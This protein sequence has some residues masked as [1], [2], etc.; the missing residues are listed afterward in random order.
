M[1]EPIKVIFL[2]ID[3]V[4]NS[5]R[6]CERN[7][8]KEIR[9]MMPDKI[10]LD[11][12]KKIIKSTKA[13]I[14]ISSAWRI[15]CPS[16][17][18]WEYFF[19]ALGYSFKVIGV[20]PSLFDAEQH[21]L[22]RGYEIDKWI[23]SRDEEAKKKHAENWLITPVGRFVIID[24]DGDM[25]HLSDHLFQTDAVDGLTEEIADRVIEYLNKS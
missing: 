22:A 20:T 24:D 7:K 13:K 6:S 12:L 11:P 3:G 1:L 23:N 2:D 17:G 10:H 8:G 25:V 9:Q 5:L 14:V 21:R 16:S 15:G 19:E 4:L 18:M